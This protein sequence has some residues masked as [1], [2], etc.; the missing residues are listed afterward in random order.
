M[1]G[2]VVAGAAF[3]ILGWLSS[4]AAAQLLPGG[5][6]LQVSGEMGSVWTRESLFDSSRHDGGM[7]AGASAQFNFPVVGG[8]YTGFGASLL[9]GDMSATSDIQFLLPVDGIIGARFVPAGLQRPLSVYAFGGPAFAA[10]ENSGI[11]PDTE[12]M[13]GWSIGAGAEVQLSQPWSVG[14]KYRHFE[15]DQEAPVTMRG[16]MV[17]LTVGYRFPIQPSR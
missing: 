8:I 16:D 3:S 7:T 17:T 6:S 14:L 2:I 11:S 15:V 10:V 9:I 5:P 1:R 13:M 12:L 4:P